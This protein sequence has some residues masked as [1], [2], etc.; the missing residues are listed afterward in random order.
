M[1]DYAPFYPGE[2]IHIPLEVRDISG[3]LRD[4]GEVILRVRA[5]SGTVVD[6]RA[7]VVR[8]GLGLDSADLAVDAPG[9]WWWR[10]DTTAPYT[11]AIEDSLTVRASRVL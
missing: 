9:T 1:S 7:S 6:R 11:G 10:W 8:G 3:T 2:V 5:P 4:P